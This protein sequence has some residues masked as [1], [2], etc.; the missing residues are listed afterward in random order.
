[1]EDEGVIHFTSTFVPT[2]FR[3]RGYG[4]YLVKA[5]LDHAMERNLRVQSSCWFVDEV[6]DR[7][8]EYAELLK[9]G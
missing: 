6:L 3:G 1:M 2:L 8:P 9:R 5:G 4:A 7:S